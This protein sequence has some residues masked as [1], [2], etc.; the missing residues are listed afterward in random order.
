MRRSCCSR[1]F[2]QCSSTH[3]STTSVALCL[4]ASTARAAA[5][6][7]TTS[8]SGASSSSSG[9][10]ELPERPRGMRKDSRQVLASAASS[11][12]CSTGRRA[13]G[14]K[15]TFKQSSIS[16]ASVSR[17]LFSW[18]VRAWRLPAQMSLSFWRY[19]QSRCRQN[20]S[21]SCFL[22]MPDRSTR[23]HCRRCSVYQ[24]SRSSSRSPSTSRSALNSSDQRS[25]AVASSQEDMK[26][27]R[28]QKEA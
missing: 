7:A 2:W 4:A 5:A 26:I 18:S 9:W 20:S 25:H 1:K 24:R 28:F 21:T 27:I 11:K 14:E 22:S 23:R 16:L 19:W 6:P 8:L 17:D 3:L 12:S 15:P 10:P 13:L